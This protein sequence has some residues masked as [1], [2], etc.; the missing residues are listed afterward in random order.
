MLA[1]DTVNLR[2]KQVDSTLPQLKT[3]LPMAIPLPWHSYNQA[4]ATAAMAAAL[5]DGT[6]AKQTALQ[7]HLLK[8]QM[9][10]KLAHAAYDTEWSG[11]D[12]FLQRFGQATSA[13]SNVMPGKISIGGSTTGKISKPE[14]DLINATRKLPKLN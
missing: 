6:T 9:P 7:N 12:A 8:K 10:A 2:L 4:N 13:V 1:V 3:S 14:Q 5:R 11:A